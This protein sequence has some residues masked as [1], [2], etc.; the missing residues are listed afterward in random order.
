MLTNSAAE[1][2]CLEILKQIL[3][4]YTVYWRPKLWPLYSVAANIS[5]G[6]VK[7]LTFNLLLHLFFFFLS[8]LISS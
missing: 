5:I 8:Q 1:W 6:S 3:V 2:K 7:I 4:M